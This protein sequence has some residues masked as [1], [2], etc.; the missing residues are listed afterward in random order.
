EDAAALILA[1]PG[2]RHHRVILFAFERLIG[3]LHADQHLAMHEHGG[4]CERIGAV[5]IGRAPDVA[6]FEARENRVLGVGLVENAARALRPMSAVMADP[7]L[8]QHLPAEPAFVA[9]RASAVVVLGELALD[10]GESMRRRTQ[11]D[12]RLARLDVIGEML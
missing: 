11:T 8:A 6:V 7:F 10:A 9:L 3:R 4:W 1:R 12:D 2:D 5:D